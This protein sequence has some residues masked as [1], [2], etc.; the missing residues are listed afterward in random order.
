MDT[1]VVFEFTSTGKIFYVTPEKILQDSDKD[2]K[3]ILNTALS[4]TLLLIKEQSRPFYRELLNRRIQLRI[5]DSMTGTAELLPHDI[6]LNRALFS[7]G[8]RLLMR[9][10][11]L[12][13]GVLE[14]AF[15]HLCHPEQHVTQVRLHSLHFLQKHPEIL[16][17]TIQE[18]KSNSPVFDEPDWLET[19]Q[20]LDNLLLLEHFWNDLGKTAGIETILQAAHENRETHSPAY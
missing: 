4:E 19:L 15:F 16:K 13:V 6:L 9:R 12:L 11:R 17:S 10:H 1:T 3:I 18:I 8:K 7:T 2:L 20:Q 5:T 14:R